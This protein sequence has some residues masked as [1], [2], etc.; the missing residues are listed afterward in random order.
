[1]DLAHDNGTLTKNKVAQ[2]ARQVDSIKAIDPSFHPLAKRYVEF[3]SAKPGD[4]V[5]FGTAGVRVD[6]LIASFVLLATMARWMVEQDHG[7][8][9]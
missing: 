4:K 6:F 3:S 5:G 1:M 7:G 2:L 8:A 9:V